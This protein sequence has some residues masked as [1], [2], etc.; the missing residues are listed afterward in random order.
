ML[1]IPNISIAASLTVAETQQC[2]DQD[3]NRV[4]TNADKAD[5]IIDFP[6][7]A[8]SAVGVTW[9]SL[10]DEKKS[11]AISTASMLVRKRIQQSAP[12]FVGSVA[13]VQSTTLA[14]RGTHYIAKGKLDGGNFKNAD[15]T[16]N[17][18]KNCRIISIKVETSIWSGSMW[19][20]LKQQPE[21][22]KFQNQ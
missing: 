22:E 17:M 12:A 20:W 18:R 7:L 13:T 11:D 3:L 15:F 6:S 10:D 9:D 19:T 16:V 2:F 1:L 4:L 5:E 21:M 8:R 14:K